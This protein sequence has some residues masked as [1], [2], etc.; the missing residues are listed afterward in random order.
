[1]FHVYILYSPSA[2]KYYVGQTENL[3]LRLQFHNELSATSYT[4][5]YRPWELKKSIVVETRSIAMPLERLIKK[6]KSR[7]YIEY[8]LKNE[9]ELERLKASLV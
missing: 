2:D 1:M 8:I 6:K 5:K 4:S 7:K 3:E 9:E